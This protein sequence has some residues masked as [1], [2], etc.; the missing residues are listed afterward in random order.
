MGAAPF[1]YDLPL[2]GRL[3]FGLGL[4]LTYASIGVLVALLPRAGPRWAFG[5]GVGLLYSLPGSVLVAVPYPLRPTRTPSTTTSPQAA[6][7]SS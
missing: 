5:A 6:W 4:M 2:L 7:R 1:A 3:F